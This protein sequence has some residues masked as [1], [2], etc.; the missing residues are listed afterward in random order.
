[1]NWTKQFL[2]RLYHEPMGFFGMILVTLV[3][4]S[5]LFAPFLTTHDHNA[6]DIANRLAGPSAEH[7]MGT[8]QLGRD[9]FSRVV[10]GS[11]I[12]VWV[13]LVTV[14]MSLGIGLVLGMMAG[15]GP[16]WLDAGLLLLFDTLRSFP[17]IMFALALVTVFGPSLQTVIIV[18]VATTF[19][20]YGRMVRTQT[21]A[22]GNQEFIV[23]EE[24]MGAGMGRILGIHILPNIIGPLFIVASMDIPVVVTIEAGLSFLGVGVR[25][26]TPSWGSILNDGYAYI[27]NTPWIIIFGGLPLIVTTLG[28]TFLGES[29]RDIFDPKLRRDL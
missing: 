6:L 28:F 29:L 15:Y 5:A 14:S 18:I 2:F 27:R 22:L 16:K 20:V 21:Q 10:M 11:R 9:V 8:D 23:A 24:A 19:P 4:L 12:A 26:P 1:M 3:I 17:T 25:P 7:W 13:A